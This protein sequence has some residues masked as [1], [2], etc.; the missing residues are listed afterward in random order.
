MSARPPTAPSS[1]SQASAEH[2]SRYRDFLCNPDNFVAIYSALDEGGDFLLRDIIHP[3]GNA[4][5]ASNGRLPGSRVTEMPDQNGQFGLLQ[6]LQRVW[7]EG[8]MECRPLRQHRKGRLIAWY[9]DTAFR[10]PGGDIA[11]V[12][13]DLTERKRREH[14]LLQATEALQAILDGLP[15]FV[16]VSDT[17]TYE[18]L[19]LNRK[20]RDKFGDV[21]GRVCWEALHGR[22]EGP[23]E[24]CPCHTQADKWGSPSA[25][26]VSE[27]FSKPSGKWLEYRHQAIRWNGS[28]L[29]CLTVATD[30]S[31]RKWQDQELRMVARAFDTTEGIMITDAD[32][33]IVKVNSAFSRLTG[34][35]EQEALGAN[36]RILKSERN[37]PALYLKMWQ[38]LCEHGN[39]NGELWNRRKDGEEFP[40]GISITAVKSDNGR[41]SHYVAHFQDISERKRFQA[42]IE[43]QALH[44]ALTDLPNRRL[45]LD[46]LEKRLAEAR[47]HDTPGSLMFLDLDNFKDYNDRLGHAAGDL[48]LRETAR[49]ITSCVR[50]EDTVA[51]FGGDEFVVLLFNLG[52]SPA[53]ARVH[54]L[55]VAEKIRKRLI[56]PMQHESHRIDNRTSIGIALFPHGDDEV[57][58]II[59]R[60]DQAMYQAKREG[61]NCIRL[62][63]AGLKGS[64]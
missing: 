10:L 52:E 17:Y 43:R 36:P 20:A 42:Q 32:G 26:Q 53:A 39:W 45:L 56:R 2:I 64:D 33:N 35:S 4:T 61:K 8:G 41:A 40:L 5:A 22:E 46:R 3:G 11:V 57:D 51:R 16:Y 28:Q 58:D 38:A 7:R 55:E 47:R 37:D 19:F 62:S 9:Q 6:L 1:F 50:K 27:V 14:G 12:T 29:V 30:I 59:R 15:S 48:I 31:E 63:A 25:V 34:Y 49:R 21:T 24:F 54:A 44:D 60:A 13:E 23:C 18:L